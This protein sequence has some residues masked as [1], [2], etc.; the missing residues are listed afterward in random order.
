MLFSYL[1]HIQKKG[2]EL[3]MK[4]HFKLYLSFVLIIA[5]TLISATQIPAFDE[6]VYLEKIDTAL[7]ERMN[8]TDDSEL[9]PINIALQDLDEDAVMEKVKT[10]TGMDPEVYMNED[11]FE[12]EVAS[13]I[14]TVLE[15]KLGYEEAHK[16]VSAD[17]ASNEPLSEEAETLS[18]QTELLSEKT[19]EAIQSAFA[20]ELKTLAIDPGCIIEFVQTDRSV[21][22]VD[23]AILEVRQ[24]FQAKKNRVL[25]EEQ[26]LFNDSFISAHVNKRGNKV[27]YASRY[28]STLYIKATKSDIL[29]YA[30]RPEVVGIF[31]DDPKNTSAPTLQKVAGQVK[32]DATT[33]TKS[34]Y[35]N[36]GAGFKGTGIKIGILEANGVMETSSPHYSSSRM[37]IVKN[38]SE[39]LSADE[40]ASLVTAIAAGERVGFN[41]YTYTGIVPEAQVYMTRASTVDTFVSG[42][43]ALADCGVN[44][45][46][47]SLV[48][49]NRTTYT[50]IDRDL[51]RFIYNTGITCVVAAG[52]N[53]A[54]YGDKTNY[55]SSPGYALNCI[56]VGN[57]DTKKSGSA[58][59]I[60]K[61]YEINESSS[62]EEPYYL[63]NKPDVCAPGTWIR[64]VKSKTG[65]NN[66]YYESS[67]YE[68]TGTS[69]ATPIVTGVVAQMMQEHSAK[70][71]NPI[72]VKAK[73]MNT[74]NPSAVSTVSN[75]TQGNFN[76]FEKSGAGLVD[77]AKAMTG[78]G[79]MY[80]WNHY[81]T[82]SDYVTRITITVPANK[83]LRTTLAFNNRNTDAIITNSSQFYD[84]DLRIVDAAT[85]NDLVYSTSTRNNVE[86]VEY[87]SSIAHTIYIQTRIYR[88]IE[89]VKTNWAL[90]ADLF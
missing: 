58:E 55:I 82:Q 61:P 49:L 17:C 1:L 39:T 46:N 63:P 83:T 67:G 34:S 75:G 41:A 13:K 36:N 81:D 74:A 4:K 70:I 14:R 59:R 79:Y 33:G 38:R 16:V 60:T 54:G 21:S 66:F 51:D 35:F 80:A 76:I 19:C 50:Y 22:I 69:F 2:K 84:M 87:K 31:F 86:I 15:E 42:L 6:K 37:H 73:I 9:I 28:I 43:D 7:L 85:G 65:T 77:A 25:K 10:E 90:E 20:D 23:Y 52:N 8:E 78:S 30:Q 18:E 57:L 53:A 26:S 11:R 27:T 44:I 62:W 29:Y 56:T 88:N 3:F 5:L 32:A 45:I 47:I 71:G 72:A 68:P 40:H 64:A 89:N 12:K 48:F 24:Q